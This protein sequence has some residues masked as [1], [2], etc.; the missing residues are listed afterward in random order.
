MQEPLSAVDLQ[1]GLVAIP[2]PSGEEHEEAAW[3]V[4][5]MG[6]LGY[7]RAFVDEAGNAV[8]EIGPEA[9]ETQG[10]RQRR[11]LLTQSGSEPG[12]RQEARESTRSQ[13]AQYPA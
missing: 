3:L 4:D 2:S 12:S 11:N 7:D 5:R 13:L 6:E 8:G 9:G 1:R 10:R